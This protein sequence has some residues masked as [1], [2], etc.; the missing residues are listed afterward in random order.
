MTCERDRGAA[1]ATAA[2]DGSSQPSI[3]PYETLTRQAERVVAQLVTLDHPYGDI[4]IERSP[5]AAAALSE[6]VRTL[7]AVTRLRDPEPASATW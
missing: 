1:H 5:E 2:G 6:C 3:D 4:I 7:V